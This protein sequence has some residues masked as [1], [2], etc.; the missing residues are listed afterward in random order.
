VGLTL[1]LDA[2]FYEGTSTSSEVPGRYPCALAGRPYLIDTANSEW[3]H[4]SVPLLR[5]QADSSDAPSDQSLNPESLW[6]RTQD[7]WQGGAGQTYRDRATSSARRFRTSFGIDVWTEGQIGLLPATEEWEDSADTNLRLA[8][9][10]A[11]LYFCEGQA[12]KFVTALGGSV[13]TVTS[14]HASAVTALVSTG[15]RVLIGC[16]DG[17]YRTNTGTSAAEKWS[18]LVPA[19]LGYV[20]GRVMASAGASIYNVVDDMGGGGIPYAAP[21]EL[22][23]HP[24]SAFT[25]VGFA[26]GPTSQHIYAAGFSGDKSLIYKVPLKD[27]GTGLDAPI[28]A[29][30]LPD[31][32]IIRSISTYLGFV[33]LGT[34]EGVRFATSSSGGDLTIGALLETGSA[35][36]CFEG[37]GPHVWFGWE[38]HDPG[39][40]GQPP[41][42]M[43]GLGRLSLEDF[44]SA[45]NLAPAYA[46]D[47]MTDVDGAVT[48]VA[49]FAGRRVFAVSG[50][51][52][53]TEDG[54]GTLTQLGFVRSGQID[55][56]LPD[57]KVAMFL[58]VHHQSVDG[59]T[60]RVSLAVDGGTEVE[61]NT[62]STSDARFLAGE[63]RGKSFEW[64]VYLFP[65]AVDDTVGPTVQAVV[66]E[67]EPTTRTVEYITVPLLLAETLSVGDGQVR[68]FPAV[69]RELI[70]GLRRD[71]RLVTYQEAGRRWSV[72]VS[73][74]QWVPHQF[75]QEGPQRD[76]SG[77]LVTRLKVVS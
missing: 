1:L 54:T 30:E 41:T 33:L 28:V 58:T 23:T 72:V 55:F 34:D 25:W 38:D 35:V 42:P 7:D 73:D 45:D 60:H 13:T 37:Q 62:A 3:G 16:S 76:V 66:L 32:E 29:G 63:A 18:S 43:S 36:R 14:T 64:V 50:E 24:D 17:I 39:I 70:E 27:D 69:E 52:F 12:T 44:A 48:D 61:L 47:L 31:G 68:C 49:T 9:A 4:E 26:G 20:K 53:Y 46:T 77:T 65:D 6:R 57:D 8:V 51:G 75:V 21:T 74:F 22:F 19:T 11:R 67:A 2:P 59:G 71:R 56:R 40:P 10:G 5:Q 15:F